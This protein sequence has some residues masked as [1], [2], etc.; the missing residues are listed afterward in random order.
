MMESPLDDI[1]AD[2]AHRKQILQN[3]EFLL[4][5]RLITGYSSETDLISLEDD[6]K[7]DHD[8]GWLS[9]R[10][11]EYWNESSKNLGF[12]RN[13][14]RRNHRIKKIFKK[15]LPAIS[16][17][18]RVSID[19]FFTNRKFPSHKNCWTEPNSP[20]VRPSEY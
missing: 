18:V 8:K 2:R 11:E 10:P 20:Q 14:L 3:A 17:Q 6:D 15:S 13:A 19:M 5:K 16:H 1:S 12:L 7:E 9:D 4:G